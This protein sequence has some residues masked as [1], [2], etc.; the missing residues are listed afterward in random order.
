M[1]GGVHIGKGTGDGIALFELLTGE[2]LKEAAA[3]DLETLVGTGWTPR[4]F[5][6]AHGILEPFQ[7]SAAHGA[8][9]LNFG[10]S[11]LLLILERLR[12]GDADNQERLLGGFG[13]F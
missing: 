10:D 8:T 5:H 7:S 2:R 11:A 13:G 3:D 12:G 1:L 9:D 6:T 4:G